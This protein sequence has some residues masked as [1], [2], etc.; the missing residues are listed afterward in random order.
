MRV[1]E[2]AKQLSV[3]SETIRR[4]L[5]ELTEQGVLARTYGGA[6]LRQSDEPVLSERHKERVAERDAIARHA[7]PLL[8]GAKVVML[9]SGATTL[10]VAKRIA[11]E[12]REITVITHAFGVATALSFNPTIR[13][14]MLPGL[15][16]S[17][18]GAMHG[19]QTVRFL[20]R[21]NADWSVIGASGLSADGPSDALPD[22]ADVYAS[23]MA[24]SSQRM[25]VADSSKFDRAFTARY[26]DWVEVGCLVTD[27]A[28]QGALREAL[29]Q[30]GTRTIVA[31]TAR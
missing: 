24:R 11:V 16:H 7:A 26:A 30:A 21:L 6:V 13:V 19:S 2:L 9:G 31:A 23:M 28:P 20:E 14:L 8:K 15:Y 29:E 1:G 3:T 4:D 10:Q 12:M 25:V 22:A 27:D 5:A 18:E 17:T